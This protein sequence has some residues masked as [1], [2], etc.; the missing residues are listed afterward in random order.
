M[1]NFGSIAGMIKIFYSS[2]KRTDCLFGP[3][4][5]QR[6][7]AE[8]RSRRKAILWHPPIVP[9]NTTIPTCLHCVHVRTNVLTPC[10]RVPLEKQ[11]DF[12]LVK[13]SSRILW[14]PKVHYRIH[15]CPP[16]CASSIQSIPRHPT[17]RRSLLILSPIYAWVTQVVSLFQVSPTKP[18]IH[19]SSPPYSACTQETLLTSTAELHLSGLIGTASQPDML[20]IRIIGFFFEYSLH[21]QFEVENRSSTNGCFRLR[22]Y[23]RANN[24]RNSSYVFDNWGKNLS[25]KKV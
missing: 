1:R 20:K 13:K 5:L 15:K 9:L 8:E 18:C 12:Q 10:S 17:S 16:A 4:S 6:V 14:N 21:W 2:S 24:I 19:L 25:H 23:L 3:S 22:T 11:A 7:S